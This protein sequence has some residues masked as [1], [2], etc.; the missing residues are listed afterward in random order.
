LRERP[1]EV[2]FTAEQL[3]EIRKV[4]RAAAYEAALAV[5]SAR[6]ASPPPVR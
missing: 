3:V 6:Q 4:A 2:V 5:L 1:I